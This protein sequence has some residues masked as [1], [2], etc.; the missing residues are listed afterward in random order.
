MNKFKAMTMDEQVDTIEHTA[1]EAIRVREENRAAE[2]TEARRRGI[3]LLEEDERVMQ[4]LGEDPPL[5]P[6]VGPLRITLNDTN[7]YEAKLNGSK[8]VP[9]E[10]NVDQENTILVSP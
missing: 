9:L 7:D 4:R 8:I 3:L 10:E 6:L 1:Q 2:A 5:N